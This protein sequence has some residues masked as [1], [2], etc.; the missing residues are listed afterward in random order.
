M[1][2]WGKYCFPNHAH[3]APFGRH[4]ATSTNT[5]TWVLHMVMCTVDVV[6]AYWNYI[7]V[8]VNKRKI[9]LHMNDHYDDVSSGIR[10]FALLKMIGTGA[11]AKG[12]VELFPLNGELGISN[13]SLKSWVWS[14]LAFGW[15][16]FSVVCCLEVSSMQSVVCLYC[17][18]SSL[19]S[20][21]FSL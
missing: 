19:K 4:S 6:C 14:L 12:T 11:Q 7:E 3:S 1:C 2:N 8:K 20:V 21:I 10:H 5:R 13:C 16:L 18:V 17:V 15:S 9:S